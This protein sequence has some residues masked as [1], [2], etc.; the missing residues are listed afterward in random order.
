M[1]GYSYVKD[2]ITVSIIIQICMLKDL[3]KESIQVTIRVRPPSEREL[4]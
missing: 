2:R 4:F 3:E 1:R